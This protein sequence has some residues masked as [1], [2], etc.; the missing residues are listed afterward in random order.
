[1]SPD[2]TAQLWYDH[3]RPSALCHLFWPFEPMYHTRIPLLQPTVSGQQND[4]DTLPSNLND[5]VSNVLGGKQQDQARSLQNMLVN[6][7][8]M[9]LSWSYSTVVLTNKSSAHHYYYFMSFMTGGF[10]AVHAVVL[11][12][13]P[14][15]FQIWST[16][17][18]WTIYT[19]FSLP[20]PAC[21]LNLVYMISISQLSS[22]LSAPLCADLSLTVLDCFF[23]FTRHLKSEISLG[24]PDPSAPPRFLPSHVAAFLSHALGLSMDTISTLWSVLRQHIWD[25]AT[26]HLSSSERFLFDKHG[27][28]TTTKH[29]KLGIVCLS[30]KTDHI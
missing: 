20:T 16:I 13:V 22:L 27:S 21:S 15:S 12:I 25:L 6:L 2:A 1:M 10:T 9:F 3:H 24:V 8:G 30:L 7:K 19:L 4:H 29:H 11:T 17:T 23:R 5:F 14:C 18:T 26:P 28:K